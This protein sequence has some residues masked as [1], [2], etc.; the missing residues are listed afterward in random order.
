MLQFSQEHQMVRTIV[1]KWAESKLAP[2]VDAL[3]AGEPPYE[4]MRDLAKTFGIAAMA[5]G[6]FAKLEQR[7]K[8][9]TGTAT[10]TEDKADAGGMG[11]A[12]ADPRD[13]AVPGVGGTRRRG[14]LA[15]RGWRLVRVS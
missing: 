10:A 2:K 11:D 5:K 12:A 13:R 1:R 14:R 6:A 15:A 7:A 3:E 8:D 9:G 4:L